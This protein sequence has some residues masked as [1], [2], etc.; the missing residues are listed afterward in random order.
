[1]VNP[2]QRAAVNS[3]VDQLIGTVLMQLR[4]NF[5]APVNNDQDALQQVCVECVTC[6][7]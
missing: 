5:S 1:M 4:M 2:S 3:H 7:C 6:W